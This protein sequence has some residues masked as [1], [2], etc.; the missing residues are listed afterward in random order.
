[1]SPLHRCVSAWR[2]VWRR[3]GP[4]ST[5]RTGL[6][7]FFRALGLAHLFAFVSCWTQVEGL[8]GPHGILPA[9]DLLKAARDGLGGRAYLEFP[10]L[11]W[12]G[13]TG[14]FL[15][16]LCGT[17]VALALLLIAN[18]SPALCL[19]GLWACYLS[20]IA[21]G[22]DFFGFQWDVLL[23]ETTL[24]GIVAAPWSL[25]PTRQ[26]PA[27]PAPARWLLV[28]LLARLM[29]LSGA[30]KL[31]SQDPLWRGLTALRVHFETQPLP[32]W[33]GWYAHQLPGWMLSVACAIMFAI[34]LGGPIL[35]LAPR[36]A[37][38]AAALSFV[39]F[40]VLIALTGNYTFFNLLTAALC[41]PCLDDRFWFRVYPQLAVPDVSADPVRRPVRLAPRSLA[42]AA[43]I[44]VVSFT[45]LTGLDSLTGM[46]LR[47]E[48]LAKVDE[49]IA[50]FRSLNNYG[51]FA[52]MTT[53]RREIVIEGTADGTTWLPYEFRW[54]PG[55]LSRAPGFVEPFQ[56]RLDW[57]MWF[58]ALGPVQQS[59]WFLPLLAHL[60]QGTPEVTALFAHNPFPDHPPREV[61]AVRY[62]YHFTDWA[63]RHAT[64]QW[65]QRTMVDMFVPPVSLRQP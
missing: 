27:P 57:Q 40:M 11:C 49:T 36:V 59:R 51:L 13:G 12:L 24:L 38:H 58:A 16:A 64:G 62:E 6:W 33:I 23:L 61:R 3:D 17:G 35:L 34:E 47:P 56:P 41:L 60:L 55:D 46:P 45:A 14:V 20:V 10:S 42:W 54:K 30:V 65:W 50:P 37:R 8:T 44:F 43:F 29:F 31:A 39:G 52:V 1:M 32:T 9:G 15:H 21:V 48:A 2:Q 25:L 26:A 53:P 22:Q 4:P 18:L 63:T 7:L 19:L 28:W 5:Y